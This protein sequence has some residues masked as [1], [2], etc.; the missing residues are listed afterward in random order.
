MKSGIVMVKAAFS[1]KEALFIYKLDLILKKK[2]VT[3]HIASIGLCDAERGTLR[4]EDHK[5]FA[6]FKMCFRKRMVIII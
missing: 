5:C 3:C 4:R 1:E 2:L 6:N